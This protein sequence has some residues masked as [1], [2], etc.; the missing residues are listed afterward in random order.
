MQCDG[1]FDAIVIGSGISGGWAAKELTEQG[2]KVAVI[3]RGRMI[4][5]QKDYHT[6]DKENWQLPLAGQASAK[7]KLRKAKQG[8]TGYA[9]NQDI[10]HWFVDDIDHPYQEQQRFDWIRGYHVGGRSITW[11]RQCLRFSDLD[12]SANKQDGHGIDW[13]VR[14]QDIAPW[15]DKVERFIGVMGEALALPQLPDGPYLPAMPLNCVEKDLRKTLKTKFDRHLT[16]GRVAHLTTHEGFEGRAQCSYRNRCMR[17][18]PTGSYFSA[19]ASTLPAAT[20]TGNLTLITD[21]IASEIVYDDKTGLAQGVKTIGRLDKKQKYYRARVIFCCA[22]TVASTALLLQSTSKRFP[23]GLGNDSG[24][25]GHY[26]MD[27]HFR[28]GASGI[29]DKF[30]QNFDIGRRPVGF[31]IPRFRNVEKQQ[32][33]F[34]RGYGYQGYATRGDWRRGFKELE[35]GQDYVESLFEPGPW[36]VTL[37]GFGECLP[38]KENK[39]TLDH[40]KLDQ[41]GLPQVNFDC[42]FKRNEQLMRNDMKQQAMKMLTAAGYKDVT[43]YDSGSAPGQ[44]IHEMGT[45]RMGHSPKDSMVNSNNQLHLVANVYVTDGAFM[46]SSGYQNP[47]LTYMAF[48]ARAAHHAGKLLSQGVF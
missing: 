20:K 27:H 35:F 15:Y 12:F 14:Y 5:H 3:E 1:A 44:A 11:G 32:Q 26:L 40:Q 16:I 19:N 18:C 4:E 33:S 7:D 10:K 45:A 37:I 9:L 17:G 31:H 48:T 6:A 41:W 47:S 28:I 24:T 22:S 23:Q 25:L 42:T 21:T 2:F 29:A 46:T 38:Y 36:R 30:A 43:P 8:R 34:V 13:P 39:L